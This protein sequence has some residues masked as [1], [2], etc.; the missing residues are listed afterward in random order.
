MVKKGE[1]VGVEVGGTHWRGTTTRGRDSGEEENKEG[2]ANTNAILAVSPL[3]KRGVFL[4][5]DAK[6]GFNNLF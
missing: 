3:G 2:G 1:P 4:M 5:I 6:N